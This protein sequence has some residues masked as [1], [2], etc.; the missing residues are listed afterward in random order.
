MY[1][2]SEHNIKGCL[3]LSWIYGAIT[4]INILINLVIGGD[5]WIRVLIIEAIFFSLLSCIH[6]IVVLK[7]RNRDDLEAG[8]IE[9]QN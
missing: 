7:T 6:I 5:V 2:F 3:L 4:F 8:L 9:P 1:F